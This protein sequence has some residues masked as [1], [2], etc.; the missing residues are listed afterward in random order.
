MLCCRQTARALASTSAS[1][2]PPWA[3]W[4]LVRNVPTRSRRAWAWAPNS[5]LL[6]AHSAGHTTV[7]FQVEIKS[8]L[9]LKALMNSSD[10]LL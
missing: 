7:D 4:L 3:D 2:S 5:W 8:A 1:T 10:F 6:E 9:D